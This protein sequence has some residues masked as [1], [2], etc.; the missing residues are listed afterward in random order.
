MIID[1]F[2]FKINREIVWV[3]VLEEVEF[4]YLNWFIEEVMLYWVLIGD[5]DVWLKFVW[6]YN[7]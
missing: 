2:V 6:V 4:D 3:D 5:M 1:E 7:D